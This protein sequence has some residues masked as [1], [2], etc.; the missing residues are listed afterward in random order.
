MT[1]QLEAARLD[2]VIAKAAEWRDQLIDLGHRNTL[3]YF[4]ATKRGS[5][6]LTNA[7]ASALAELEAGKRVSLRALFPGSDQHRD[8]CARAGSV[9]RIIRLFAEEQGIDVGRVAFGLVRTNPLQHRGSVPVPSLRAPLLLRPVFVKARTA[10]ESDFSLEFSDEAEFNP[11]L[12]YALDRQFG[13]DV[14]R[15]R[16]RLEYLLDEDIDLDTLVERAY[17]ELARVAGAQNIELELDR[18]VML[19]TFNYEKLPMVEDLATASELLAAHDL[20]AA[21]AD[22]DPAKDALAQDSAGYWPAEIDELSPADE[23]LVHDADSSQHRAVMAAL[24]GHNVFIEGPPGTGKSQTIANIIAGAAALGQRVLF[25]A[26]KRAA[27]EAVM[28]RL[29]AVG[30]GGL[31]LDLHSENASKREVARQL[32]ES[33]ARVTKEPPVDVV[34]V[35]TRLVASRQRLLAHS[36]ALHARREPWGLSAYEV[37]DRL[38]DLPEVSIPCAFRGS[39]LKTLDAHVVRQLQDDLKEFVDLGGLRVLRQETPWCRT[40]V[41][42]EQQVEQILV[43]LDDLAGHTLQRSQQGMDSL[44]RRAGL[45]NPG[46]VVGWNDVLEL[47]DDVS[48]TVDTFGPDIF[49]EKLELFYFAT[50]DRKQRKRIAI[51]T[52]PGWIERYRLIKELRRMTSGKISQKAALHTALNDVR[53]QR[54]R[55]KMSGGPNTEP[56]QVEGLEQVSQD[57]KILRRQLASVAASAGYPDLETEP[58]HQ[59]GAQLN[60]LRADKDTLFRMPRLNQYIEQFHSLGLDSFLD[61]A[62]RR[63]LAAEQVWEAFLRIWLGSLDDEFKLRVPEI[64]QFVP[65]QLTR[66]ADEFQR[67]DIHH[68]ELAA[69]RVRRNVAKQARQASDGHPDQARIL[70]QQASRKTRH[71]PTRKLVEQA[72]DVMLALRP[73]WAMSPLVASR[74]LPAERLFDLVIFDE[75]SQIRPHDAITSIMRGK[76]VVVAGDE[77][78]LPPTNYFERRLAS[79]DDDNDDD[80]NLSDYESILTALRPLL[81]IQHMLNWHYRSADERLIAFSNRELYRDQLVTFPGSTKESPVALVRVDGTAS[82]GQNGSSPAELNKVV[83]L[84]MHHARTRPTESLGVITLNT[85][86]Q[87][88]IERALIQARKNAPEFEEFFAADREPGRRFFIKNLES[89]QGDERDAIILSVGVAR[90]AAGRISGKSFGPL[91]RSGA[92]RRINVAVTRARIR[93]TVVAAFSSADLPASAMRGT[94]LLGRYLDFAERHGEIDEVGAPTDTELNGFERS[95]RDALVA[96][97]VPVHPQWG[98]SGYCIDFALAHQDQ[99]GRMILAVEADGHRYHSSASARDRDRLRQAHLEKLGWRFH[100]VWSSA[101]YHN[102]QAE[103]DKILAAWRDAMVA[104]DTALPPE[105]PPATTPDP[106]EPVIR[107]GLRPEVPTGLRIHEYSDRELIAICRWLMSDRLHISREERLAQA[108]TELGFRRRGTRI[109]ERLT[110]AIEAAQRLVDR[111]E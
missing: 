104:A 49:G 103:A 9:G 46:N 97:D 24:A 105:P 34:D 19:G 28:N 90:D 47:L 56:S 31:M 12:L 75:A 62:A 16:E 2:V 30:L 108:M 95:I 17:A 88:R 85:T 76:S 67:A 21:L 106:A 84:V 54:H 98:I 27:I 86:H 5:L 50:G 3:L 29:V 15:V 66:A 71:M 22:Y 65:E 20:V 41:D 89:V 109:T 59:V 96:R 38:L 7:E 57:Y 4:R 10:T 99:P 94:A 36:A 32:A 55:W 107:R 51:S 33:L 80:E 79:G 78:Q 43:E 23:F 111:E 37:R 53:E 40:K 45:A 92:E 69:R 63:N 18:A 110:H 13:I 35:H 81:P 52:K 72:S 60:Q 8:A 74:M 11:V 58:A 101:W 93:M 25:V 44:L 100:R 14:D 26:E 77:K 102:P 6:D 73:C 91:N 70:Q 83:E 68:R 82:P 48:G 39:Q 64:G 87:A 1:T 42:N 61:E